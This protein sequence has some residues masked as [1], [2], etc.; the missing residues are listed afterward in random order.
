[1]NPMEFANDKYASIDLTYF[2]NGVLFNHIPLLK[3]LKIREAVTF[4]GLIG[5]LSDRNNP[6]KNPELYR[7]PEYATAMTM[8]KTP[9]MEVG[10]GIDNILTILRVDYVWRLTY[11]DNPSIDKSGVRVSLHFSF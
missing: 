6:E 9:Y 3:R 10:A 8:G 7:F 5:G 11:R 2:G 4:K 1:M